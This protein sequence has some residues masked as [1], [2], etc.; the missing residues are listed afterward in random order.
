MAPLSEFRKDEKKGKNQRIRWHTVNEVHW[1]PDKIVYPCKEAKDRVRYKIIDPTPNITAH[2]ATGDVPDADL[3]SAGKD[4]KTRTYSDTVDGDIFK[5]RGDAVATDTESKVVLDEPSAPRILPEDVPVVEPADVSSSVTTD[6]KKNKGG[7]PKKSYPRLTVRP[8]G[9]KEPRAKGRRPWYYEE[10]VWDSMSEAT[11]DEFHKKYCEEVHAD[12]EKCPENYP[13]IYPPAAM[14]GVQR[15]RYL[16]RKVVEGCCAE[17]SRMGQPRFF[18]KDCEV[19]RITE[20][21]DA[22][23]EKGLNKALAACGSRTL[24]WI[25]I[26]CIGGSRFQYVNKRRPG[27]MKRLRGRWKIFNAIFKKTVT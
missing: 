16:K 2:S 8:D 13:L 14:V 12:K 20:K 15:W 27:G 9:M 17:D 4:G 5:N 7:R 3:L 21:D 24:V 19:V 26:P 25:S 10:D 22:R 11:K 6:K 23:S 18:G 1:N